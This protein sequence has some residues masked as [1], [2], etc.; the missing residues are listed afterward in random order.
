MVPELK[1]REYYRM[2]WSLT[3][4]GI[5]W[6]EVT[7]SCNLNC[8]GCYRPRDKDGH[9]TLEQIA[10][11]LEVFKKERISDCM[12]IA[13]GDPLVHP[14]IVEIVKLIKKGGWKPIL[15]TNGVALTAELLHKLKEAGVFGFTFHVDTSQKRRDAKAATTEGDL[16]PLRLKFAEMLAREGGIACS[17]NQTVTE[18]TINQVTD[19]VR[20]AK[21]HPDIVHTIVFILFRAPELTGD[22]D[23]YANG[24]RVELNQTYEDDEVWSGKEPL[25]AKHLVAKIREVEPSFEPAGYLSGTYD[26]NTTKWL[27]AARI[28]NKEKSFGYVS[29]LFM[30]LVQEGHHLFNGKWISYSS[31]AFL[32]TGKFVSFALSPFDKK[33]RK[34]AKNMLFSGIRNPLSLLKKS[35]VQAFTIIQPVDM[36]EDGRMNMCDACPDM[37]VHNGKLYWS[38]RLEEIKKYGTFVKAVPKS[39]NKDQMAP[40]GKKNKIDRNELTL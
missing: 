29:P 12:S 30:E 4:N 37:T 3:D 10:G 36:M 25:Q 11:E 18:K 35:Y 32:S 13:G 1:P 16:N 24:V 15:N 8:K 26:P 23:F 19:V 33:M 6:I 28:A 17:F 9:K 14:Q 5:S 39:K 7:T 22:Y 31:P 38:C 27:M 34:V 20:W 21:K 2:P 40:T